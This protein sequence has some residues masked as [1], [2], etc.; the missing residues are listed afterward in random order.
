MPYITTSMPFNISGQQN[1]F[2]IYMQPLYSKALIEFMDSVGW[3]KVHYVYIN[4]E[5]R[6]H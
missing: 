6:N 3:T 1:D 4:E 5:G 2:E